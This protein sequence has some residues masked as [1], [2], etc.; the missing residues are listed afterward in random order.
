MCLLSLRKRVQGAL[1]W[2]DDLKCVCVCVWA[3]IG[4]ALWCCSFGGEKEREQF[5][6]G[7]IGDIDVLHYPAVRLCPNSIGW[8]DA[9]ECVSQQDPFEYS[10]PMSSP[11]S[12][13]RATELVP[14][15]SSTLGRSS[16]QMQINPSIALIFP[17]GVCFYSRVP[18]LPL[19]SKSVF[20][21]LFFLPNTVCSF[22]FCQHFQMLFF[23][24][25]SF[26]CMIH[27][28]ISS[29]RIWISIST[30]YH[31]SYF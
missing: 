23:A 13:D 19:E 25:S 16:P 20:C 8:R 4:C 11:P 12:L 24:A 17:P 30:C 7:H 31:Y 15:L 14:C 18:H 29:I 2:L 9:N 28:I 10:L 5:D 3:Q 27:S 21:A 22:L 1:V 6:K 26:S